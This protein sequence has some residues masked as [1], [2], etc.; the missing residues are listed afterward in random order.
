VVSSSGEVVMFFAISNL[1]TVNRAALSARVTVG[2][3]VGSNGGG[4]WGVSD[5]L[6]HPPIMVPRPVFG[7][8]SRPNVHFSCPERSRLPLTLSLAGPHDS[9]TTKPAF[10]SP[11]LSL[12]GF[13]RNSRSYR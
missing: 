6:C 3:S 1:T 9:D 2:V 13:A 12:T 7:G 10:R 4:I 11:S 5:P 8:R